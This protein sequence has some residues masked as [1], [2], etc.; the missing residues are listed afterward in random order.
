MTPLIEGFGVFI[1]GVFEDL[2]RISD[3]SVLAEIKL[4]I[5]ESIDNVLRCFHCIK[6]LVV[7]S[8]CWHK[9]NHYF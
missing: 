4:C 3:T 2:D 6:I 7:L 9:G 1:P 5:F 8:S